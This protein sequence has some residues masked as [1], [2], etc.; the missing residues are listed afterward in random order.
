MF[1]LSLIHRYDCLGMELSYEKAILILQWTNSFYSSDGLV[2]DYRQNILVMTCI[3]VVQGKLQVI[4]ECCTGPWLC[5]LPYDLVTYILE[6]TRSSFLVD[7]K[8]FEEWVCSTHSWETDLGKRFIVVHTNK[9]AYSQK[10]KTNMR[11][12]EDWNKVLGFDGECSVKASC[13]GLG[14]WVQCRRD[15]YSVLNNEHL[16]SPWGQTSTGAGCL[17]RFSTLSCGQDQTG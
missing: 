12:G 13:F 4:S 7:G 16:L 1:S 3:A 17:E 5:L 15:L 11:K 10:R 9:S 14:G 6:I 8:S 2:L